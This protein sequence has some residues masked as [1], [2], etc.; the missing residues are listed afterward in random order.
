MSREETLLEAL[1]AKAGDRR[2]I[3]IDDVWSSFRRVVR[4]TTG[5][6]DARA[7]LASLLTALNADGSV[8]FP[9]SRRGWDASVVPPLPKWIAFP[10]PI[11]EPS[12]QPDPRTIA[13]PPELLF[14]MDARFD[15]MLGDLLAS[16]T[17]LSEGGRQR[18]MVPLRERSRRFVW[19][20]N[21]RNA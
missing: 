19:V 5:Q 16:K 8:G 12:I 15:R 4:G 20:S 21:A 6:S 13:W 3:S 10:Q 1:Q 7:E 9:K 2:R 14:A 17:F 18:P 11:V